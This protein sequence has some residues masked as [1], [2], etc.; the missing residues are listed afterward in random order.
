MDISIDAGGFCTDSKHKYGN[1]TFTD[2]LIQ[3]LLKYDLKNKYSLYSF[4]SAPFDLHLKSNW[5]YKTLL[6]RK[7][8]L[9][10][11]VSLEETL[12]KH[13]IFLALN[14]AVP[15]YSRSQIISFSHGLS[16]YF[17]PQYY[18][19][20]FIRL[21]L[22]LTPMIQK[23]KYI[24]VSSKKVKDEMKTV[25]PDYKN[26]IVL[27]FGIPFDMNEPVTRS[28]KPYF[29]YVGMNHPIKNINFIIKAFKRFNKS[30]GNN[31]YKLILVGTHDI[32][33]NKLDNIQVLTTESRTE[34]KKLYAEASCY[35]TASLYESFNIPVLE[36][37]SQNCPVIGL[38]SAIIP[39]MEKY[40][41]TVNNMEEFIIAMKDTVVSQKDISINNLTREFSWE[42]YVRKLL[43][44]Y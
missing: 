9:K 23:S 42:N 29:L 1:Y 14:Q 40:V 22:Q 17:F 18:R 41:K 11:R 28:N 15:L 34:L 44:L 10:F 35:L 30:Y 25:Y 5:Q 12:H 6:P 36:A 27:P 37:L 4:C 7:L 8:W 19:E 33:S 13:D 3:A 24:I 39:E 21:S 38:K 26:V 2:N 31:K 32:Y 20:S 16:Y 43:K